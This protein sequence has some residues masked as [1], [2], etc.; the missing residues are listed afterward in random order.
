VAEPGALAV[1]D[2]CVR[3][4]GG[5]DRPGQRLL[6]EAVAAAFTDSH[7][8]VAQAPTGSGKS[9]AYLA[10]AVASGRATVVATAT[11]ALQDQLWRKDLPL[12]AEQGGIPFEAAVLK[13]RAQY[14]CLARLRGAVGGDALFDERPGPDFAAVLARLERFAAETETGDASDAAVTP[15]VWRSVS[16][17]PNECPGAARC[18]AGEDCFAEHARRRA[19][20][21]DILV[22]N[23]ALYLAHLAAGGTL[24]PHHEV[25]IVDEAHAFADTATRALGTEVAPGGVRHLAARLRAAGTPGADADAV[26]ET[27]DR[28][29]DAVGDVDGRVDPTDGRLA[30][31]LAAVAER[32]AT[33][34]ARLD[35]K[36][37]A[38]RAAQTA[39][40]AAARLD[41]VRR[42]QA[43]RLDDVVWVEGGD[44]PVL[45][46]APV[47]VG[48]RLAPLLFA[49]QTCVLLSAT[50][51]PG[52]RFEPFTGRL[53]LEPTADAATDLGYL[54]VRVESPFDVRGQSLLYVPRTMP[55]P[56]RDGWAD[57]AGEELCALVTAAGGR[58]LVLCTS[59]RAVERF[60][61][62]LRDRTD[63]PVLAQGDAANAA[64]LDRFAAEET[65]CLVATRAFWQGVDVPGPACVLVVIDRVPFTRPDDPLEQARR[66]AVERA[67]GSGFRDVDLPAAALVLA[68]GAGR[69]LRHRDDRGVVAVLDSRLATAGYRRVLLEALPPMRRTVERQD[70]VEFLQAPGAA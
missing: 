69:L 21:A 52:P 37:D 54:A 23:H 11:L 58:T 34:A 2:A 28:L 53:G 35:Q 24:L 26:A 44:R 36:T 14:L 3:G 25:V 46:L 38:P 8:L 63:H 45:R 6:T 12:V 39:R 31:V 42:I 19:D 9:L 61:A 18:P 40:L 66:E 51:G 62:L 68:Q 5:D 29:E 49:H 30:G 22:V 1:L 70:V 57:A 20:G 41:A 56:R 16:C 64:L 10:P 60:A 7:H 65:S 59:R 48:S 27:A 55:D 67:G 4:L 32:I 50:L 15:E 43:P 17:G 33:A 47:D 13:G